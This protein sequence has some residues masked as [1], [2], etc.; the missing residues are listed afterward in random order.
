MKTYHVWIGTFEEND[1]EEYWDNE[2]YENELE[3]WKKGMRDKPDKNLK[4]GFCSEMG[5]DEL[6]KKDFWFSIRPH[7]CNVGEL[8]KDYIMAFDEF[9]RIC[10]DK[11]ILEGNVIFA[12]LV[13]DFPDLK[14][15][16]CNSMKY[17][18]IIEV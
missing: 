18:G 15:E 7:L 8:A 6:D 9:E 12:V 17:V 5:L 4:C 10:K 2:P 13:T 1:F 14:P 3:L 11:G 16:V